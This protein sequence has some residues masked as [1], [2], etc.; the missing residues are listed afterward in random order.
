M[1]ADSVAERHVPAQPEGAGR[2]SSDTELPAGAEYVLSMEHDDRNMVTVRVS[3][4]RGS[5]ETCEGPC[6]R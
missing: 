1:S 4:C 5:V 2:W 3:V 6:A